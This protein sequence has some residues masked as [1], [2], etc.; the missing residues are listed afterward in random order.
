M[1]LVRT[2][3]LASSAICSL[4]VLLLLGRLVLLGQLDLVSLGV[5]ALSLCGMAGALGL[6]LLFCTSPEEPM[7]QRILRIV[8]DLI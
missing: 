5:A 2:V 7:R 6:G 3:L 1:T 4:A 8:G